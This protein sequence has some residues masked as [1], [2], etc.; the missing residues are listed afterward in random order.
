MAV[1]DL[2]GPSRGSLLGVVCLAWAHAFAAL[3]P[4]VPTETFFRSPKLLNLKL[5]PSGKYLAAVQMDSPDKNGKNEGPRLVS[6]D[7][8]TGQRNVVVGGYILDYEWIDD[9]R[10][11]FQD[12]QQGLGGLFSVNRD[13]TKLKILEPPV[14]IQ[15]VYINTPLRIVNFLA[16]APDDPNAVLV[17]RSELF[18]TSRNPGVF[19][20][21][22]RLNL[23]TGKSSVE[24]KNP[25]NVLEWYL[26]S[27]AVVRAALALEKNELIVLYRTARDQKWRTVSRVGLTSR[28]MRPL[29]FKPGSD[30]MYVAACGSSATLGVYSFDCEKQTLIDCL[31][32]DDHYDFLRLLPAKPGEPGISGLAFETD[33]LISCWFDP[34]LKAVQ[35]KVDAALPGRINLLINSSRDSGRHL[36]SSSSDR[37]FPEYYLVDSRKGTFGLVAKAFPWLKAEDMAEQKPI[38]YNSRD[39][40]TIHGYLTLP[41]C[42]PAERLPLVV[43]PHGGPWVRDSWGADPQVQ[44]LA[45]RGYAV[46]QMN[47]RGSTGYGWKFQEAGFREWGKKMQDDITDGVKWA[48]DQGIADPGRIAI[49]GS[50]YGGYAALMGLATTPELY[51]CGISFAGVTDVVRTLKAHRWRRLRNNRIMVGDYREQ[52]AELEAVS[53]VNLA[54]QIK[55]PVL[56]AHGALDYTVEVEQAENMAKALKKAGK[57]YSLIIEKLEGHGFAN[58]TNRVKLFQRVEA[59][60]QENMK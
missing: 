34:A 45:N 36:F 16:V 48:I 22:R 4:Q 15:R 41:N 2:P 35:E 39:G 56:L 13:S 40:L 37:H 5:S 33:R 20:D 42:V 53:P 30:I 19:P 17:E 60:L 57:K 14:T 51:R 18:L 32:K 21:V 54:H 59:F 46:L 26:D 43:M 47:F 29:A 38:A 55:A 52:Q 7:I 44:F 11:L 31:W 25:G 1:L 27:Q 28:E 9:H 3:S 10:F 6:L 24:E 49:F 8:D 23:A 50:S 12:G 58:E